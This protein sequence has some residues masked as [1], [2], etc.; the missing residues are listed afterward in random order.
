MEWLDRLGIIGIFFLLFA[1]WVAAV[2]ILDTKINP[3]KK[4]TDTIEPKSDA[5]TIGSGLGSLFGP[6]WYSEKKTLY[7]PVTVCCKHPTKLDAKFC[8]KCGKKLS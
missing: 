2:L 1:F 3:I 7:G 6:A 8:G 5:G 4:K